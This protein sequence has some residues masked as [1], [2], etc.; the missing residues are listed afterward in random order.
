VAGAD[1]KRLK[2]AAGAYNRGDVE[3]LVAMFDDELDWQ[4]ISRGF[5][6]WQHTPS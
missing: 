2:E 5:L 6:W 3:P 4:G 1:V